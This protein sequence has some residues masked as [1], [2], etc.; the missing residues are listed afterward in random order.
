MAQEKL[1]P[2]TSLRVEDVMTSPV[3][4]VTPS[5]T[6]KEVVDM[7]LQHN[8]SGA[9]IVDQSGKVI[10]VISQSD[11]IQFIAVEGMSK[12]VSHYMPRLP[13]PDQV[14]S[15]TKTDVFKEVFKQFLVKPVRRIIVTDSNGKLQG[16]VS[17]SNLLRAFVMEAG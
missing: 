14:I 7:Y 1:Q 10:S 2:V 4:S 5:M 12:P 13:K 9:P 11:L 15:V 16:I 17:K 6:L 3:R 8:I